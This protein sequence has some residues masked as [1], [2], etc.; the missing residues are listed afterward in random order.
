MDTDVIYIKVPRMYNYKT[1]KISSKEFK[2]FIIDESDYERIKRF[3]WFYTSDGYA[4]TTINGYDV[5]LHRIVLQVLGKIFVDHINNNKQDNRKCNL[6]IATVQQNSCNIKIKN[7]DKFRCVYKRG[8]SIYVD[9]KHKGKKYHYSHFNSEEQAAFFY[10]CI[11]RILRGK[12]AVL[13]EVKY[14]DIETM[15]RAQEEAFNIMASS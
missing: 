11:I 14:F 1:R 4:K 3:K 10:N 15:K 7:K 2:W 6:R 9:L 8:N 13:N 5:G 12:F